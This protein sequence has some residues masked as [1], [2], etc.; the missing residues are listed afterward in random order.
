[1]ELEELAR[2][3]PARRIAEATEMVGAAV[4]LASDGA[5]NVNGV[6]LPVDGSGSATLT[7]EERRIPVQAGSASAP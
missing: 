7:I 5:S 3:V 2:V 6:T 1:V 4:Y